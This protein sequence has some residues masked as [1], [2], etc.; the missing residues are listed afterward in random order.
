M[1]KVTY[2][3]LPGCPYCRQADHI[4][5]RLTE[6]DPRYAAVEFERVNEMS[7]PEKVKGHNYWYVP[8]MFVGEEKIYEAQPGETAAQTHENVLRVLEAALAG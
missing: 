2:F 7:E 3:Y 5:Q 8:S 4:L 1:K 6:E